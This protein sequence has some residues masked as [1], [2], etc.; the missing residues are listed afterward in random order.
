MDRSMKV[1]I[2][3]WVYAALKERK[4]SVDVEVEGREGMPGYDAREVM[5]FLI[6]ESG[7]TFLYWMYWTQESHC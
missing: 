4:G 6:K 5:D 2:I 7:R 1:D 3:D